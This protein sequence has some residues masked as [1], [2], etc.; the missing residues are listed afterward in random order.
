MNTDQKEVE[1]LAGLLPT[2]GTGHGQPETKP[3]GETALQ[4]RES[5]LISE[6][7]EL[8][9]ALQTIGKG[10]VKAGTL[11]S[12][13]PPSPPFAP[14]PGADGRLALPDQPRSLIISI[15]LSDHDGPTFLLNE[16]GAALDSICRDEPLGEAEWM[17]GSCALRALR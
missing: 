1:D 8:E 6:K 13:Q 4:S 15:L 11:C 17:V 2:E 3:E 5:A 9:R 7:A 16:M 12:E 14:G 10:H